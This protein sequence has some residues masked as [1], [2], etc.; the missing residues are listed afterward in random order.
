MLSWHSHIAGWPGN[1]SRSWRLICCGLHRWARNSATSRRNSPLASIRRRWL[2]AR[3]GRVAV[4]LERPV[5][6]GYGVAAQLTRDRRRC[7]AQPASDLP[8]AQARVPQISDLDPLVLRQIPRAD[9]THGQPLQRRHK[10]GHLTMAVGL[11]TA[12]PVVP[13]G[14]GNPG[15]AGRGQDAPPPLAQLHEPLTLGR[16][17][18]PPRPLLHPTRRQHNPQ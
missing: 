2:Q 1:R 7:P 17:R 8:D 11:V 13:R 9:L 15:L 3:R 4:S 5:A 12:R 14:P 6:D 10:P 16:L 18:T